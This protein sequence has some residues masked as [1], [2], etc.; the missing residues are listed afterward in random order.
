MSGLDELTPLHYSLIAADPP[1][2]FSTYSPK[3]QRSASRHYETM[4][5]DLLAAMPVGY[6]AQRDCALLLWGA[7]PN[8]PDVLRVMAAWGFVFKGKAF[9]WAKT[10]PRCPE[11]APIYSDAPWH[12]GLGYTT[13]SNTED[14]WLGTMGSPKRLSRSVRELIVAPRREHSRK[15]D[16]F[17]ARAEALFDGPRLDLFSRERRP[18]WDAWGNEVGKFAGAA[19]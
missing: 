19:A 4:S 11:L 8:L 5:A 15:P 13:R 14:C 1:W 16:E 2:H 17:Y 10:N 6:L 12:M 9:C 3:A 7:S 18:G